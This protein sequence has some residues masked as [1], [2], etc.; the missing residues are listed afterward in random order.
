MVRHEKDGEAYWMLPGGG[1]DVGE[2]L[3]QAL[4]R[5]LRE[6]VSVD[7]TVD[8]LVLVNDS[9]A[10]DHHRHI[11]NLYFTA[12][13]TA[14]TPALGIDERIVEVAFLPLNSLDTVVMRPDFGTQLRTLLASGSVSGANYWGNIW[15]D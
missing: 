7:I 13:I 6:E 1:V 2:G 10:P 15:R 4:Q 8:T 3:A 5:E 11:V 14:G 12:T 9:I